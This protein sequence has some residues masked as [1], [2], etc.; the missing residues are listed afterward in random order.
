MGFIS[1]GNTF[2]NVIGKFPIGFIIW[3][4]K[5]N[6][7]IFNNIDLDVYDKAGSFFRTKSFINY[8]KNK[9]LN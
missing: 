8:D 9:S 4:L 2:D 5:E 7:E 3:N 1:I 6:E